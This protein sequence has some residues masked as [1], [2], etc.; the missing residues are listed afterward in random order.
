[1][2]QPFN[3]FVD[4]LELAELGREVQAGRGQGVLARLYKLA[5]AYPNNQQV[6]GL[7]VQALDMHPTQQTHP[8]PIPQAR[9]VMSGRYWNV[10]LVLVLLLIIAAVI[11]IVITS[12][13]NNTVSFILPD[14]GAYKDYPTIQDAIDSAAI[15]DRVRIS[16]SVDPATLNDNPL[17]FDVKGTAY[18]IVVGGIYIHFPGN[19]KPISGK[20][21]Y[22]CKVLGRSGYHDSFLEVEAEKVK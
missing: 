10:V 8:V 11:T 18:N 5:A 2:S 14:D 22:F 20:H 1:M 17:E 4:N 13:S 7:V 12:I 19:V 3:N 6:K 21:I 15:G 16:A 9:R